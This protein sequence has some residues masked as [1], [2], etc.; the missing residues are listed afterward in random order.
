MTRIAQAVAAGLVI[1]AVVQAQTPDPQTKT[2]P[3]QS[4]TYPTPA[5]QKWDPAIQKLIQDYEVA[6]N[7]GD[8]KAVAALYTTDAVLLSPTGGLCVGRAEIESDMAE[9]LSGPFKWAKATL[10]IGR[11]Q[12]IKP[13]VALVQGTVE[14][15]GTSTPMSG[16]YLSTMVR[17]SGEWQ[18]ASI[19]AIPH[20]R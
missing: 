5:A 4:P 14:I 10:R 6:F 1:V 3:P 17:E 16:R 11:V 20:Q 9:A 12:M 19:A 13:D 8:A 18:L 15:A 2:L 7:K